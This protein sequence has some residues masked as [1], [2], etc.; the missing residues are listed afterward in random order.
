MKQYI[1]C[2]EI[3]WEPKPIGYWSLIMLAKILNDN[4]HGEVIVDGEQEVGT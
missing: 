2:K 4:T 3:V 1:E